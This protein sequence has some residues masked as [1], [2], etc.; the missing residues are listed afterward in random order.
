VEVLSRTYRLSPSGPLAQPQT[1]RLP[2]TRQVPSGWAVIVATAETSGGPWS[3]LPATLSAD[4]RTAIF[5]T[6]HHSVFTVIGE[7]VSGLLG[8]FKTQFLD[9]LS[10]GDCHRRL[11]PKPVR[12]A[13]PTGLVRGITWSSWGGDTATGTGTSD[14]V[15]P[16]QFVATGTQEPVTIVAFNLGSCDGKLMYQAVEWYFPQHGQ[17]FNPSQYENICT[18]TY[19]GQ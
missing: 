7:D 17:T 19:V 4:R 8:F 9:G 11:R 3:Y 16:N 6:I 13:D 10:S 12:P 15:G 2:L 18:G 14:Y 5:T 1:V